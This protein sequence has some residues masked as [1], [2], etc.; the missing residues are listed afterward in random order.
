MEALVWNSRAVLTALACCVLAAV[1]VLLFESLAAPASE[2]DISVFRSVAGVIFLSLLPDRFRDALH[3]VEKFLRGCRLDEVPVASN[4]FSEIDGRG[5]QIGPGLLRMQ[6]RIALNRERLVEA[7]INPSKDIDPGF[8]PLTIV[9]V[10]GQTASGIYHKHNN[11]VRSIYDTKG[12]VRSFKIDEIEEMLPSKISI[13]PN[14][15]VDQMTLQEF[16]DLIAYLLPE[17]DQNNSSN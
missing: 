14:G 11:K 9:T 12:K 4:A 7:I 17:L 16:R 8:L 10:D 3:R 2:L 15:L 13:M 5:Q 1:L 6:G